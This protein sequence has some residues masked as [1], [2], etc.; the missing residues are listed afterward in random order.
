MA[1]WED[2][3]PFRDVGHDFLATAR[4]QWDELVAG[5]LLPS[6]PSTDDPAAW[7]V[8]FNPKTGVTQRPNPE[9]PATP[10]ETDESSDR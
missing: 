8:F 10:S 2:P 6:I 4:G 7:E 3:W 1:Q 5:G 9:P